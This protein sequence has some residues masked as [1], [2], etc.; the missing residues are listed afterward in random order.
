MRLQV[1]CWT[2]FPGSAL[3]RLVA[4]H[5]VRIEEDI[6]GLLGRDP[7]YCAGVGVLAPVGAPRVDAKLLDAFPSVRL[8]ASFGLGTDHIDLGAAAERGIRVTNTPGVVERPTAELTIGLIIGLLRRLREADAMIRAGGWPAPGL[9]SML[10]LGLEG[11]RLG[12]IGLGGVGHQV[13][14]LA[15]AF[16]MEVAYAQRHRRDPE[17]ERDLDVRYLMLPELLATS[18]VVTVH[19]PLTPETHHLV[20][21]AALALMR[22]SAFLINASRGPV[23]DEAALVEALQAS[24]IAGAALDVY[25]YEPRVSEQL[26]TLDNVFLSAHMGSATRRA[27]T[28]MTEVL[29]RQIELHAAGREPQHLVA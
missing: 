21:A 1:L 5:D 4:E 28:A 17:T 16:G 18:D 12:I 22:P 13:A 3:D 27:R 24:A 19:C 7:A 26:L 29:V 20:D 23:V 11:S 14:V 15:R 2:R 9:E 10:G 8:I 6:T 25:E